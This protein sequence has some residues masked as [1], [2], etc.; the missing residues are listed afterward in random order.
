[1]VYD[2]N[3]GREMTWSQDTFK[4]MLAVAIRAPSIYNVQPWKVRYNN[5]G[6]Q[7]FQSTKRRLNVAD[8]KLKK[9]DISLGCFLELCRMSLQS[10]G[11]QFTLTENTSIK[12]LDYES[13]FDIIVTEGVAF[14]DRLLPFVNKRRTYRGK[15]VYDKSFDENILKGVE[16]PG[17]KTKYITDTIEVKKWAILFDKAAKKI[18]R[19]PGYFKERTDWLRFN[20]SDPRYFQ[21]GLNAEAL[22]L[23]NT[24]ALRANFLFNNSIFK[25]L[26]FI[27]LE[28]MLVSE[29]S[30]IISS[31]G[32]IGLYVKEDL[33]ALDAGTLLI[34]FWLELTSK[35]LFAC[36]LTCLMDFDD[37]KNMLD[38]LT[39]EKGMI[40]LNVLRFGRVP[41]AMKIYHSARLDVNRVII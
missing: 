9:N 41:D 29:C 36:P 18:N 3:K 12:Y 25:V 26:S 2:K 6:F 38:T 27:S 35:G 40:C 32:I 39:P 5:T 34:R 17:L 15:F 24:Q 16:V 7:I 20:V 30:R 4:D 8:P 14:S 31:Q 23:T 22:A 11:L 19:R 21:D 37:T 1:M 13:R 33:Q 10:F 28:K